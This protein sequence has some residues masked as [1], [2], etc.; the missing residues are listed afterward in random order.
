MILSEEDFR[1]HVA[2]RATG[3]VGVLHLPIPCH[4]HVGDSAITFGVEDDVL[5]FDIPMDDVIFMEIAEAL[6]DAANHKFWI[7]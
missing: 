5:G 6:H 7:G 4:S 3:L 1:S 2:R